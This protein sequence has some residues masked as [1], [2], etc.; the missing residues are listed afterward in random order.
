MFDFGDDRLP[1]RFWAKAQRDE[2][3]DC[4]LW[5]AARSSKGYGS[6]SHGGRAVSAHRLAYQTLVGSIPVGLQIDHLCRVRFCVNPSHMETVTTAENTRRGDSGRLW[7]QKTHCPSGHP[8]D[9]ANTHL[10]RHGHRVCRACDRSY[11]RRRRAN[12]PRL[13][14][15]RP[16]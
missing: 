2:K 8:Y 14:L 1:A 16:T 11:Q 7:R 9:E 10:N 3:I 5:M 12:E 13:E 4:W 15:R 6:Y